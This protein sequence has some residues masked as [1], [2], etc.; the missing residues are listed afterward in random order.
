[1]RIEGPGGEATFFDHRAEL[2]AEFNR[3]YGQ[4]WTNGRLDQATKEVGRIR[5]ARVTG[6]GI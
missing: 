2:Y 3:F 4:L 5:N 1:M 6:C